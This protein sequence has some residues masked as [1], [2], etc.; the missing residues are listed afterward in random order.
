M[1]IL[2]G[3]FTK[4]LWGHKFSKIRKFRMQNHVKNHFKPF[5]TWKSHT[6]MKKLCK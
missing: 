2:K 5:L 6:T 1:D 4:S 3:R